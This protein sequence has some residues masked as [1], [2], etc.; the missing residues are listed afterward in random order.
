MPAPLGGNFGQELRKSGWKD[1]LTFYQKHDDKT[2]VDGSRLVYIESPYKPKHEFYAYIVDNKGVPLIGTKLLRKASNHPFSSVS[3]FKNPNTTESKLTTEL[4][5]DI[6]VHL[7]YGV[8]LSDTDQTDDSIKIWKLF[9]SNGTAKAYKIG[10]GE[11]VTDIHKIWCRYCNDVVLAY[12]PGKK[13]KQTKEVVTECLDTQSLIKFVE[14]RLT[15]FD[16][17]E[18]MSAILSS[19]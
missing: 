19:N 4:Y 1:L 13:F 10:T 9:L 11:E 2:I 5:H 15:P 6:A 16:V 8:L 3:L 17:T 12:S 14:E 7:S 18:R